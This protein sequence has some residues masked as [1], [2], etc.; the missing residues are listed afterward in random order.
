MGK[1]VA[2]SS[3]RKTATGFFKKGNIKIVFPFWNGFL[4]TKVYKRFFAPSTFLF[5]GNRYEKSEM[6]KKKETHQQRSKIPQA[7]MQHNRGNTNALFSNFF[8]SRAFKKSENFQ[9]VGWW[10]EVCFVCCILGSVFFRK[11]KNRL[12]FSYFSKA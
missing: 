11:G 4:S 12:F 5:F 9:S 1:L 7:V 6:E 3:N 10:K 8:P 2:N